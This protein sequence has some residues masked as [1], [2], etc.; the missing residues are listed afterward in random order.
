MRAGS[1]YLAAFLAVLLSTPAIR[2]AHAASGQAFAVPIS[3]A[4][5][6]GEPFLSNAPDSSLYAEGTRAI[7]EGRWA[8]AAAIFGKVARQ[9]SEHADGALY[10]K[11]YALNK[12][13]QAKPALDTCIE[14]RREYASS[15]WIDEC[16]ALEIEIRSRSGQPV[17]PTAGQDDEL[18]LLALNTLMHQDEPRAM[19]QI[20]EILNGDSSA[21]LKSGA[22]FILTEHHANVSYSQIVRVSYAKGDVRI[23]RGQQNP[24]NADAPWEKAVAGLPIE[25]GF[26]LVTG[27]G[28]AEIEFENASTLYLG[29]NSALTFNDLHTTVGV[30]Y[31]ELALLT[32]TVSLD[33][34]PFM[35]GEWFVLKTPADNIAVKYPEKFSARI[36]SYVDAMAITS[37]D[38]GVLRLPGASAQP[39]IKGQTIL[40]HDGALVAS[41][42]A[43]DPSAFAEWDR[44]VANRV[45]QRSAA[46]ADVMKASG[47]PQPIPGLAEMRGQGTFFDCSPYG[48]CWEP[49]SMEERRQADNASSASQPESAAAF[50]PAARG[51]QAGSST[52]AQAV[53]YPEFFPC[54]P[55]AVRY[56]AA[57]YAGAGQQKAA[58]SALD[59][60]PAPYDWAVCHSGS[61]IQRNHRYVWVA[62]HRRRHVEPLH[63]IKSGKTVAFVP[64]H[65][66]DIKDRPPFN[67][68]ETAFAVND[69]N[70]FTIDRVQLDP[71][72]PIELLKAPPRDL[73]LAPM[74]QLA[75]A[76]EPH[77][78]VHE[79]KDAFA[80]A[81]AGKGALA[82]A[83]GTPLRFDRASQNFMMASQVMH[84]GKSTI[85]MT[86][87]NNRSGNLQGRASGFSGSR[88]GGS[89][90]SG[91]G[92]SRGGGSITTSSSGTSTVTTSS[93]SSTSIGASSVVVSSGTSTHH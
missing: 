78:V 47:L 53:E 12:Q 89:L 25:S 20:E 44:W 16:G 30:P 82:K 7:D 14:L 93:P 42:G 58:A 88:S 87:V 15:R 90:G 83:A 43:G 10:W 91:G 24:V 9:H 40:V 22:L 34:K 86:P 52:S 17:Q 84:G 50:R 61:W 92:G 45:A 48:T 38:G 36:D 81:F 71:D 3:I 56:R 23:W 13:G 55:A 18:K 85:V 77:V 59:L 73:R 64:L 21:R 74:Q 66:Y 75:R 46:I 63:W 65:P 62:S 1:A 37:L 69:K 8:D 79:S 76:E 5:V 72:R 27:A 35:A 39:L 31:S 29:E 70:G 54:L 6:E 4:G 11:A 33:I 49:A 51:G 32:G 57:R 68:K 28:R 26:T 19:A 80:D 41:A 67:R 2:P 60:N